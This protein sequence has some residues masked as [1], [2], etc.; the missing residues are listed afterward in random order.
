[1]SE[2]FIAALA[3]IELSQALM[4][5]EKMDATL[6]PGGVEGRDSIPERCRRLGRPQSAV[7]FISQRPS[8]L[9]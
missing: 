9:D 4:V 5:F 2:S 6:Y 3:A 1:M 7:A 8:G